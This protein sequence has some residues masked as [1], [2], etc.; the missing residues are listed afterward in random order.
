MPCHA[1][2]CYAM[3]I[4]DV[5]YSNTMQNTIT[6]YDNDV[7]FIGNAWVYILASMHA[8]MHTPAIV[9]SDPMLCCGRPHYI[10][11]S[12]IMLCHNAM[13]DTMA[14]HAISHL[15]YCTI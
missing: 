11:L 5:I 9:L 7:R 8:Y 6:T 12:C 15:P 2:L 14:Y 13:Y 4:Y 1:M 10:R 3:M